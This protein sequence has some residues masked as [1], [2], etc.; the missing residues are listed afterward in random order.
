MIERYYEEELRYLYDSGREFAKAHPDR[1]RYLNIDAVG[2]RDPYVERLFEGF[3]FLT[4]RVREKLDDSFPE[5][6]EALLNQLWPH[7]LLEV[8]SVAMVQLTPRQGLLQQTRVIDRGAEILARP[9]GP[10]S[11][12]CRF[13]TAQPVALH[14]LT[15]AGLDRHTD[16]RG[17][18]TITFKLRCG[19]G[20]DWSSVNA[21]PLRLYVYA[22][23]P[24]ALQIIEY[25]TSRVRGVRIETDGG[26]WQCEVPASE[27]TR[28]GGFDRDESLLPHDSRGFWAYNLL[29]EY[30][31]YPEKFLCL[32]LFGLDRLKELDSP[33]AEIRYSI[34]LDGA[35][36]P[37]RRITTETFR[38]YCTP[39]VNLFSQDT[40]PIL[41]ARRAEEYRVRADSAHPD[42][43]RIHS[44][45]SVVGVNRATGERRPYRPVSAFD[46]PNRR[47]AGTYSLNYRHEPDGRR[48]IGISIDNTGARE[49][50]LEE[51]TLA[52]EAWCTNGTVPRD[53]LREG[54]LNRP[55]RGLPDYVRATNITRPSLPHPP[56]PD[57]DQHW[58]FLSHFCATCSSLGSAEALRS[59][60]SAYDWSGT[61]GTRRRIA[62][63]VDAETAPF[64]RVRGG[65]LSR[66][67][68]FTITLNEDGFEDRGEILLFGRVLREFLIRYVS[69]N[70]FLDVQLRLRPSSTTLNIGSTGGTRWPI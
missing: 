34:T 59:V 45:L 26:E 11:T 47:R 68:R 40:D 24:N 48:G 4:A 32:D 64:E 39:A 15:L 60:L 9:T 21:S 51:E 42:S 2:D 46:P 52:I 23:V 12:V 53:E 58:V 31:A 43:V 10:N 55:G 8:P 17:R 7:L 61:E 49:G 70:S 41:A 54:D 1:A 69:I 66:G 19:N 44:V 38:L 29:I 16:T 63:I 56:P 67:I 5:L 13:R 22:E 27:A 20:T 14:P 62:S 3:A 36:D 18:E 37:A 33:P 57:E 30:F 50:Q 28:Q 65:V 6:S 35:L 25:L